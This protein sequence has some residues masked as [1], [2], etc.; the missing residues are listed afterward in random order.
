MDA[1]RIN[2]Q[3]KID[4][5]KERKCNEIKTKYEQQQCHITIQN[6]LDL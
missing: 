3:N 2:G 6:R 4:K 5:A 1:W